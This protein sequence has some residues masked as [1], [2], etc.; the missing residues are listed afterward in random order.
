MH[1][2]VVD[3][4]VGTMGHMGGNM[5]GL[6]HDD[7]VGYIYVMWLGSHTATCSVR[8]GVGD[9]HGLVVCNTVRQRQR[10]C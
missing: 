2:L 1:G 3:D 9:V 10:R 6:T 5:V 4:T 7:S 8:L